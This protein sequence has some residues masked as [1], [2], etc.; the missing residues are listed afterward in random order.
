MKRTLPSDEQLIAAVREL[1][2]ERGRIRLHEFCREM[3]ISR[4]TVAARFGSWNGL[5]EHAGLPPARSGSRS[6]HYTQGE[7]LQAFEQ[8]VRRNGSDVTLA[9][10]SRETGICGHTVRR[11]FGSWQGLRDRL[12]VS[13]SRTRRPRY[14]DDEL[15]ADVQEVAKFV[16]ERLSWR[17]LERY[18]KYSVGTYYRRLGPLQEFHPASRPEPKTSKSKHRDRGDEWAAQWLSMLP[19]A[20]PRDAARGPGEP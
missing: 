13:T 8:C 14:T 11:Y 20:N 4:S 7:I 17:D 2:D 6:N 15:R 12:G 5:R 9:R 19:V 3:G 16:G 10:F 18:G 1:E